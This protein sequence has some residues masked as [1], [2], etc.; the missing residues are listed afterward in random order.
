MFMDVVLA[1]HAAVRF[2]LHYSG[3]LKANGDPAHKHDIRRAF[4]LQLAELWTHEP[5]KHVENY[6]KPRVKEGDYNSLRPLGPFTFVPLA[7]EEAKAVV[8]L[9]ITLLRPQAPGKI[10]QGGDIDNRLKTLFDALTKPPH[11]N[12]LPAS[13]TPGPD[14]DPFFTVLEDDGQITSVAVETERLL[15]ATA[16]HHHVELFIHIKVSV[17]SAT[18][19]NWV[20]R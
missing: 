6:R 18:W 12:A 17:A 10:V 1:L 9:K 7:T 3:P 5:L 16:G 19:G 14:E 2:M 15:G 20:F 11:L 8:D 4:H 13:S